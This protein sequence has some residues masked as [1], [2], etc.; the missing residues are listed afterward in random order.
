[1]KMFC[2][3]V[4]AALA[5]LCVAAP[6]NAYAAEQAVLR[7]GFSITFESRETLGSNTRLFLSE[8]R[9]SFTDVAT[10]EI[11]SFAGVPQPLPQVAAANSTVPEKPVALPDIP[12]IVNTAAAAHE[13]DPDL[14][15]S[16]IRAESSFK[17]RARSKKGA[18]GLMQLMPA[19]A[20]QLGI[21][22]AFDASAN[23]N[24]GTTHLRGLLELNHYDLAKALAAYNAG[25]HRVLQYNG[26]PPYRET[27]SY[28]AN[29]IRDFNRKKTAQRNAQKPNAKAIPPS[30]AGR[31]MR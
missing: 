5:L 27:R 23:V 3:L 1:M 15:A 14:V 2:K 21:K 8:D 7:N 28:V 26:V 18:Q 30:T 31:G 22:D 6:A 29:I 20:R 17:I 11:V 24:G 9:A 10:A 4:H 12:T 16:V 13:L 25:Q 19:T